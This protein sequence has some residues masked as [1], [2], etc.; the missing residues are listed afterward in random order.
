MGRFFQHTELYG[1]TAPLGGYRIRRGQRAVQG[2]T[3]GDQCA[4]VL[5][6]LREKAAWT[7]SPLRELALSEGLFV[8]RRIGGLLR[9]CCGYRGKMIQRTNAGSA[10]ARWQIREYRF[11]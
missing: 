5:D 4:A 9:R 8:L 10:E 7:P 3:Y 11:P 6:Q 1:V 2:S